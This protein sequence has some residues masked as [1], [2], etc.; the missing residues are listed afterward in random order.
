[1]LRSE[2]QIEGVSDPVSAPLVR[3]A[4]RRVQ[5][6]RLALKGLNAKQAAQVV[7]CSHQTALQIYADPEFRRACLSKLEGAFAGIDDTFARS[8]L[9]LHE[10]LAEK[11][12][13]AFEVLCTM[14]DSESTHPSL[15]VKIAQ[16][17]LDRNPETQAGYTVQSKKWDPQ[18]L[19]EA[20]R[21]A[22]E[23]DDRVIPIDVVKTG[24][25]E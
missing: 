17:F 6:L 11:S 14:L 15:R 19:A 13:A 18:Q 22:R 3:Q 2:I 21:V 20:A 12:T 23:M 9:S 5:L 25:R 7:G 1:M 4:V 16:D 24:T 10:R 8:H